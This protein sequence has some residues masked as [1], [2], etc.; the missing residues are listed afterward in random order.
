VLT[1]DSDLDPA[2]VPAA[3]GFTTTDGRTVPG[4]ASYDLA[5]RT[6]TVRAGSATGPLVV[7]VDTGLRDIRGQQP[8]AELRIP[9]N[10]G[11]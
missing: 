5:S 10:L 8:V 9:V 1:F 3:I 6:V 7:R 2:T 4:T 11:G